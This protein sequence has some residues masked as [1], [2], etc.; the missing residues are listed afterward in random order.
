M[1]VNIGVVRGNKGDFEGALKSWNK[2]LSIYRKNG[3]ENDDALVSTVL[4]HMQL[5][6]ELKNKSKDS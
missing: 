4:S 2:A 6:N 1:V 5:A 3:L